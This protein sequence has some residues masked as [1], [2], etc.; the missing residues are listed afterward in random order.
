M[1]PLLLREAVGVLVEAPARE[2]DHVDADDPPH[3]PNN[4][5]SPDFQKSKKT[6]RMSTSLHPP[7]KRKNFK[8]PNLGLELRLELPNS[9]LIHL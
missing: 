5:Q 9:N 6:R 3:N 2:P 7:K 4:Q 1:S 8:T